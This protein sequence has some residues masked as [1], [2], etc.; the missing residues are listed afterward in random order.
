MFNSFRAH[1]FY[2]ITT[3]DSR[4]N[5][6]TFDRILVNNGKMM[7]DWY[8]GVDIL[9]L[10]V[11][12]NSVGPMIGRKSGG[13]FW[14]FIHFKPTAPNKVRLF[15]LCFTRGLFPILRTHCRLCPLSPLKWIFIM[16]HTHTHMCLRR[17]KPGKSIIITI[18]LSE[19]SRI[20][21]VI[22]MTSVSFRKKC[23]YLFANKVL[24]PHIC[25]ALTLR[26]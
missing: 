8:S 22:I 24:K 23:F 1:T 17:K 15:L 4:R 18:L 16:Q 10:S 3:F 6:F 19:Y 9:P 5:S 21:A 13:H 12:I 20:V 7:R 25:V 26:M 14:Y 11:S 2:A